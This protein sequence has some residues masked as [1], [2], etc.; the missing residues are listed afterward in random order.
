VIRVLQVT[1]CTKGG[2]T[3]AVR[4]LT[5]G[6]GNHFEFGIACPSSSELCTRPPAKAAIHVV[7]MPHHIDPARDILAALRLLRIVRAND[8]QIVHLHSSKAGVT[9][10]LVASLLASKKVFTPH[11]LR[12]RAYRDGSLLRMGAVLVEKAICRSVNLVVAVSVD[13]RQQIIEERI[14]APQRVCLV[15]NGVDLEGLAGVSKLSRDD[16]GVPAEAFVV[17]TVGRLC[18]QKA[19]QVFVD[20]AAIAAREIPSAHFV[21]V[22]DGP[23]E[24]DVRRRVASFGLSQRLHILG[25][26]TDA[27]EVL[28]LFDVF[29]LVSRY[30]GM[31][32]VLLEA[33]AARKPLVCTA[34]PGVR[35]LVSHGENGLPV[36]IGDCRGVAESVVRLH[37]DSDLRSRL[38]RGAFDTIARPRS[39]KVM[40]NQWDAL[41]RS[42]AEGV[43]PAPVIRR[44][45]VG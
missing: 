14:A 39:L 21:M 2:V 26:R 30:E 10:A 8:Y 27:L 29:V 33:A 35:S 28:K 31:P 9:G 32:F 18:S 38:S 34:A 40:L 15:E 41:Y 37:R 36:A 17:G 42:L 44:A 45:E 4:R 12:S 7:E 16:I 25:W 43:V 1:E 24:Q 23:L 13:E 19:P 22:G 11:A 20:A 3:L 5:E 6:L